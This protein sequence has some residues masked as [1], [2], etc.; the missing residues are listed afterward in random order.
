MCCRCVFVIG[1]SGLVGPMPVT[2][3]SSPAARSPVSEE[4]TAHLQ[5]LL[6][7]TQASE[8]AL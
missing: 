6:L 5:E 1:V 7:P 8:A 2:T 3:W 4:V